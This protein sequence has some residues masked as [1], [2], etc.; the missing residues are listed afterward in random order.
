M[1]RRGGGDGG[2]KV[3]KVGSPGGPYVALGQRCVFL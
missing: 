2:G 3:E 1:E